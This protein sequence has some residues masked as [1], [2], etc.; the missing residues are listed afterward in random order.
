MNLT[1][2]VALAE[3]RRVRR[4]LHC[5]RRPARTA[6]GLCGHC[7]LTPGIRQLYARRRRRWTPRWEIHIRLLTWRAKHGLP[8]FP[9]SDGPTGAAADGGGPT[10]GPCLPRSA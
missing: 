1:L 2:A 8:L 6:L 9:D 5:E 7:H 3:G 4:C 10:P